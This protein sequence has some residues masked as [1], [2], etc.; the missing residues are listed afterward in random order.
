MS[1]A[2]VF[3]FCAAVLVRL[4]YALLVA[5][6]GGT[7]L[8]SDSTVYLET[9]RSFLAMGKLGRVIDDVFVPDTVRMPLYPLF[10]AAVF[11][12]TGSESPWTIVVCQSLTD[13]LTVVLVAATA[14]AFAPRWSMP[15]G[16]LA[17][18][19]PNLVVHAGEVLTDSLFTLFFAAGVCAILWAMKAAKPSTMLAAAGLAFGAAAS[20]RTVMVYF[21]PFL[22]PALIWALSRRPD[23]GWRR[24]PALALLPVLMMGVFILPRLA[25]TW[26]LYGS[27]VLTTYA[28]ENALYWYLPC[29]KAPSTN[30]DPA[31]M[32]AMHAEHDRLLA[33][34]LTAAP[35][36]ADNPVARDKLRQSLAQ[37]LLREVPLINV[38]LGFTYGVMNLAFRPASLTA[39]F[40]LGLPPVSFSDLPAS[41]LAKLGAYLGVLFTK[42]WMIIHLA[43]YIGVLA[44]R[45]V[46]AWGALLLLRSPRHRAPA[47]FLLALIAY[48]AAVTGPIGNVRYRLP[49]EPILIVVTVAGASAKRRLDAPHRAV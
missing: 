25:W 22:L 13:S 32:K 47:L 2:L 30:C 4:G 44:S 6:M 12:L 48:I 33:E 37:D 1:R 21:V 24:G 10:I 23:L 11:W 40:Q 14:R 34:R 29:L 5:V 35:G 39:L 28:G 20:T 36:L 15:A 26:S 7:P 42:P 8:E 18:F 49:L 38:A 43:F 9:A 41:G 19:W 16:W 17:C 46:Q 27:P 45:A 31:S 3:L